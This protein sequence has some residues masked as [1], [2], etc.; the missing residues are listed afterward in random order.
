MKIRKSKRFAVLLLAAVMLVSIIPAS[1]AVSDLIP[2]TTENSG[3][4]YNQTAHPEDADKTDWLES[5]VFTDLS[6]PWDNCKP[7]TELPVG[8]YMKKGHRYNRYGAPLDVSDGSTSPVD[9]IPT[10]DE[11]KAF[12]LINQHRLNNGLEPLKWDQAAQAITE[13]RAIESRNFHTEFNSNAHEHTRPNGDYIADY[14][15]GIV[16]EWCNVGILKGKSFDPGLNENA[17]SH[18]P[19]YFEGYDD[20]NGKYSWGYGPKEIVKGWIESKGHDAALKTTNRDYG[21]VAASHFETDVR[22][23]EKDYYWYYNAIAVY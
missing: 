22:N 12:I 17:F 1:A 3:S 6:G 21:A 10:D 2:K 8:G 20:L 4:Y 16:A 11:K 13:T 19:E 5:Y 14:K 7:I 15:T 23:G 18:C 9:G